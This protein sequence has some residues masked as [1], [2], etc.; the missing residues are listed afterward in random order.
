MQE[1]KTSGLAVT[2][3][4]LG[5]IGA[6]LSF[7]PIVNNLSFVLG[8]LAIVFGFV[9]VIRKRSKEMAIAGIIVSIIAIGITVK[10]QKDLVEAV[11]TAFDEFENGMNTAISEFENDMGQAINEFN[12]DMAVM[13]GGKTEKILENN[14]D[15]TFGTF[16]ATSVG[17]G[18]Y[19][20]E[21][22]VTIAN[23]SSESKSFSIQIEAVDE[24]N[25]RILTDN[26]YASNLGAGQS[27]KLE[28][29]NLVSSDKVE[30]LKNA[31]FKIVEVSMY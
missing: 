20:T 16:Q 11:D 4:V 13:T 7:I 21:L 30:L 24:N 3:L 8:I 15:V 19:D 14:L 10:V 9:A 27:Q 26:V 5:I 6:C 17:F 25:T 22:P 2:S 23:K 29:F 12:D 28:A 18:L 1:K 31:T